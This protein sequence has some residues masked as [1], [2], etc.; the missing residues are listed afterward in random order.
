MSPLMDP[1]V[2]RTGKR[3]RHCTRTLAIDHEAG[4]RHN[5]TLPCT[6]RECASINAAHWGSMLPGTIAQCA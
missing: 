2:P 6:T 1:R 3:L 5:A 4:K